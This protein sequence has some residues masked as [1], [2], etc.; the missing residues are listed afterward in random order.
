MKEAV[1]P[2]LVGV[3]TVISA[4]AGLY[5]AVEAVLYAPGGASASGGFSGSSTSSTS[6]VS[7]LNGDRPTQLAIPS[8]GLSAM[9]DK[10]GKT[11]TGNVGSPHNLTNV[12]WFTGGVVPGQEGN[13]LM[14]GH[15]DNGLGLAGVFNRLGDVR[16]GSEVM[17]TL[18]SGALVDF[19]V[20]GVQSYPYGQVPMS[21]LLSSKADKP[22]LR[23]I[24]CEGT[25]LSSQKTYADRLVVTAALNRVILVK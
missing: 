21:E 3:A 13:A 18:S 17:V 9:V 24:T 14:D 7:V 2:F 15:V 1:V 11:A 4:V 5:V 22:T 16:P 10:V 25:W 6:A 19:T 20:T 12:G 23:L 8:I